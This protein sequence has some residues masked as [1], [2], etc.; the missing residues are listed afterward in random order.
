MADPERIIFERAGDGEHWKVRT[1]GGDTEGHGFRVR[2]ENEAGGDTE[3]H[4]RRL[5]GFSAEPAGEEGGEPLYK[6]DFGGEDTEGHRYR[7]SDGRLKREVR[8]L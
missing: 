8:A 1:E 7:Y 4:A 3:G 6:L 2:F 5:P